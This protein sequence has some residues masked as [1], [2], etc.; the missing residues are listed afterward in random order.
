MELF[1]ATYPK[2]PLIPNVMIRINEYFYKRE[3]YAVAA[4][5]LCATIADSMGLSETD[6]RTLN[7]AAGDTPLERN[8]LLTEALLELVAPLK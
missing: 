6:A 8:Q 1:A 7:L 4:K 3:N 2:S 5:A